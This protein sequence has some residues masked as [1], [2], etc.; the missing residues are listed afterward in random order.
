[1][2]APVVILDYLG[3]AYGSQGGPLAVAVGL[4]S[5]AFVYLVLAYFAGEAMAGDAVQGLAAHVAEC[6]P[7]MRANIPAVG[8]VEALFLRRWRWLFGRDFECLDPFFHFGLG[9]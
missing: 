3:G 8:S 1:V 5:A 9:R 4:G 7:R 2:D 6:R